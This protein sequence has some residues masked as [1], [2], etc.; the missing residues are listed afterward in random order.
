MAFAMTDQGDVVGQ[1]G[2]SMYAHAFRWNYPG[3]LDDIHDFYNLPHTT[4]I[5]HGINSSGHIVGTAYNG[6]I[7]DAFLWTPT[8]GITLLPDFGGSE[9]SA[10]DINDAGIVAGSASIPY[11]GPL[12]PNAAVKWTPTGIVALSGPGTGNEAMAINQAGY[13]VGF[14]D[15][16]GDDVP[17]MLDAK[18]QPSSARVDVDD[19]GDTDLVLRFDQATL[20]RSGELTSR[21]TQLVVSADL[22][23]GRGI[24]VPVAVSVMVR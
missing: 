19:D 15:F 4:S 9:G 3:P 11:V 20:E 24:H 23:E 2:A 12:G 21:T 14:V 17:V 10:N 22:G 8:G 16:R 18:R 5:A 6:Y 7:T 1:S 13:I